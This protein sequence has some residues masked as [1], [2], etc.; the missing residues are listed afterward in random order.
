MS[1]RKEKNFEKRNG[2]CYSLGCCPWCLSNVE[3]QTFFRRGHNVLRQYKVPLH[4]LDHP[5]VAP[6]N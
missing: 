1:K 6:L 3:V 4:A 5:I 2:F